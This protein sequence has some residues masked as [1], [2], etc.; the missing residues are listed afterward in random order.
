M[1]K[2]FIQLFGLFFLNHFFKISTNFKKVIANDKKNK[3]I[4]IETCFFMLNQTCH[5]KFQIKTFDCTL[6]L[7]IF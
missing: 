6:T 3:N 5:G 1:T 7:L 4:E 2:R